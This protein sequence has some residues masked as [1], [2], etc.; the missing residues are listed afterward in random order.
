MPDTMRG[1]EREKDRERVRERGRETERVRYI[2]RYIG[3]RLRGFEW[4]VRDRW[5]VA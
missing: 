5:P 4:R 2:D 3:Q 1:R